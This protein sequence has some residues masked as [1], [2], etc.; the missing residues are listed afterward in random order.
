[1][2]DEPPPKVMPEG[3]P[4]DAAGVLGSQSA[5][6]AGET[7]AAVPEAV[8]STGVCIEGPSVSAT[9]PDSP[10]SPEATA[11]EG[12]YAPGPPEYPLLRSFESI[13][14]E[15][16]P[17]WGYLDLAI[18]L[19]LAVPCMLAGAVLGLWAVRAVGTLF[20]FQGNVPAIEPLAEQLG[21][22]AILFSVLALILRMQHDRPFWRSLGW[23]PFRIPFLW[24][25]ICGLASAIGVA[26]LGS[27]VQ[28]PEANPMVDLMKDH[29]SAILMAFFGVTIAPVTEELVFRGFLQPLLVRSLGAVAGVLLA[30]LPFGL[31]HYHEYGNS[32]RHALLISLAG[33]GFGW[34]RH[35][36]GSTEASCLMHA[37]YNALIFVAVFK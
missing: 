18:F 37:S 3:P 15:R 28:I 35:R 6:D 9:C 25:V 4:S 20:P 22:D 10:S 12:A 31:L 14:P 21:G 13:V 27:L 26:L 33:V 23:R 5:V 7:G 24:V 11:T 19:V 32:W 29:S 8:D 30:A 16:D 1:M 34:M 2:S 36:S 17:F